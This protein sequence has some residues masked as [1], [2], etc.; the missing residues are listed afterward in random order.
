M[1]G[2]QQCPHEG[3]ETESGAV[4]LAWLEPDPEEAQQDEVEDERAQEVKDEAREMV[5]GG[6]HSPDHVV[7]AQGDPGERDEAAQV[8]GGEHPAELRPAES[9]VGPVVEEVLDIVEV[10]EAV[11][12]GGEVR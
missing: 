2:E 4:A 6:V 8:P 10:H 7:E 12:E 5:A 1:H 9:A 3:T 11:A